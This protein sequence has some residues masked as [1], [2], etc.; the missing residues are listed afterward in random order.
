MAKC[1]HQWRPALGFEA[2]VRRCDLCRVFGYVKTSFHARRGQDRERVYLFRCSTQG[3]R[4]HAVQKVPGRGARGSYVW[5]CQRHALND[6]GIE[7][8]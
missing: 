2:H 8:S 3:C 1:D 7:Q 6:G 4:G 5:R